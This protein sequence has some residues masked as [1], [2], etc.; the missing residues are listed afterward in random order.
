VKGHVYYR[1]ATAGCPPTS[2]REEVIDEVVRR[3][4]GSIAFTPKEVESLRSHASRL[5]A[6]RGEDTQKEGTRLQAAKGDV[7]ARLNRLVD[8]F[9]EGSIEKNIFEE[10]QAALVM[11]RSRLDENLE[12]LRNAPKTFGRALGIVVER[13]SNALGQFETR[14][15]PAERREL[16][17]QL[18]LNRVVSGKNVE[19]TLV[20]PYR[21][22]ANERNLLRCAHQQDV[23]LTLARLVKKLW[24]WLNAHPKE[25]GE[26]A[27]GRDIPPMSPYVPNVRKPRKIED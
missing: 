10:R 25:A 2:V 26:I 4:L 3:E 13:A 8:A 12:L 18:T 6:A 15:N 23:P 7:T 14:E 21:E 19:V 17:D 24:T 11:E 1:C 27:K 9:V 20:E 5:L 16:L 22:L